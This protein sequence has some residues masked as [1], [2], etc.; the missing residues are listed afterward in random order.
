MSGS[1]RLEMDSQG[2]EGVT[3]MAPIQEPSGSQ[4]GEDDVVQ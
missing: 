3:L 4:P 2:A 1:S